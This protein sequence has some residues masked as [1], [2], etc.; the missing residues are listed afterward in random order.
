MDTIQIKCPGCGAVLKNID[1][2]NKL[3]CPYCGNE[4]MVKKSIIQDTVDD[5]IVQGY[6]F[7]EMGEFS[8][9]KKVFKTFS[10]KNPTDYQG[11]LGLLK[12]KTRNFTIRDNNA[13]FE[14][15][16]KRYYDAYEKTAT[17]DIK[18]ENL[19]IIYRYFGWKTPQQIQKE[20]EEQAEKE[21][22][23]AENKK[24]KNRSKDSKFKKER[25]GWKIAQWIYSVIFGL[26]G[27][28]GIFILEGNDKAFSFF[29]LLSALLVF[30]SIQKKT[31][32]S[33]G[34]MFLISFFVLIIG[35]II[36]L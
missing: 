21:R 28:L 3:T 20:I 9:A 22:K 31:N 34:F 16:V 17:P 5:L 26:S 36:S 35:S 15:E 7:L 18:E 30:P 24:N 6:K 11:W 29:V 27:F 2:K 25:R 10:E 23:L 14:S 19:E 12:A 8:N 1:N 32:I 4:I 13:V 33:P